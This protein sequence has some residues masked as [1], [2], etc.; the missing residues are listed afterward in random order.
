MLAMKL[1]PTTTGF[2]WSLSQITIEPMASGRQLQQL[3]LHD[4]EH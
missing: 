3:P 1:K 2:G 4:Y